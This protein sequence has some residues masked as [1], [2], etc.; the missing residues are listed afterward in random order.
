MEENQK[1]TI[2]TLKFEDLNTSDQIE[3]LNSVYDKLSHIL[4]SQ[5]RD[6]FVRGE[7]E[8]YDL[9][10][11]RNENGKIVYT[12]I[13][14]DK[15]GN[16]ENIHFAENLNKLDV[17]TEQI[18]ALKVMNF[19]ITEIQNQQMKLK[20]FD[21]N[22]NKISLSELKNLDKEIS[23][24]CNDLGISKEELSYAAVIDS[25]NQVKLNPDEIKGIKS[26]M[27]D[28]GEK[29]STYY[30][31][32][33]VTGMNYARYQIIKTRAGYPIVLGITEDGLAEKIDSNRFQLLN[34]VNT[35]SLMQQNGTTKEA[36]VVAAFRIKSQSRV[37][38]DQV[39]G[40]CNDNTNQMTAFYARGAITADK[41][42]GENIPTR[43]YSEH[44]V[45]QEKIMD[46]RTNKDISGEADSMD[47]RTDDGG[48]AQTSTIDR[49]NDVNELI[50]QFSTIYN[51]EPEVLEQEV[52]E[53]LSDTNN[54]D[55]TD[56]KI[57]EE[58]A[59]ELSEEETQDA[60]NSDREEDN[61]APEHVHGT[62][63][64]NPNAHF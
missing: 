34:D 28:G 9:T 15:D 52:M 18:E 26:D 40:L 10:F 35:M 12:I 16:K 30:R 61:D 17:S 23:N 41:M 60:N 33:D 38:R 37:D 64:G 47:R 58:N 45:Q 53:D 51:V 59:I 24:T 54:I 2:D 19:D 14:Q 20:T 36:S 57:V 39:I 46:T 63:W 3:K 21:E 44:R 55:K 11:G 27:I 13:I 22:P 5:Y 50:E 49:K 56:E 32:N 7:K 31:M 6:E 8:I 48:I 25:D 4:Y 43:I 29:I 1:D 62:P 42:I